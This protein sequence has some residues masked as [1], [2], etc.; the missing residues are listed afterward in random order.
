MPLWKVPVGNLTKHPPGK[1]LAEGADAYNGSFHPL[2]VSCACPAADSA[3][4]LWLTSKTYAW[5]SSAGQMCCL[6]RACMP[7]TEFVMVM[8]AQQS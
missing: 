8:A 6:Q 1:V 7:G 2:Q 5:L 3:R 4:A